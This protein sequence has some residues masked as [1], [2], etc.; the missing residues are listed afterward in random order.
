[1]IE[2]RDNFFE[3][4]EE[5]VQGILQGDFT[6]VESPYGGGVFPG[7]NSEVP[8]EISDKF[9]EKLQLLAP[10]RMIKPIVFARVKNSDTGTGPTTVHTDEMMGDFSAHVYLSKCPVLGAGTSFWDEKMETRL[11]LVDWKFNRLLIHKAQFP[12]CP[13][14]VNGW[15]HDKSDGRLVLTCFFKLQ[16]LS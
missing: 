3:N 12:H 11:F 16:L 13:E 10:G 8:K 2:I 15:G 5:I 1:M 7:I 4:P 6:N 9:L 14:P